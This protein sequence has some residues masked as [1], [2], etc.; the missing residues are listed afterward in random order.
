MHN[1][2][3][4]NLSIN[5]LH[6]LNK[7]IIINNFTS[8]NSVITIYHSF[9]IGITFNYN[10]INDNLFISRYFKLSCN[11]KDISYS[12][13]FK[14]WNKLQFKIKICTVKINPSSSI[15]S[16]FIYLYFSVLCWLC[17]KSSNQY[18]TNDCN[19]VNLF[20]FF[21]C[22]KFQLDFNL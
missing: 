12:F 8:N 21:N 20:N 16:E 10:W 1:L 11:Q 17:T 22:L 5:T 7:L 6:P 2:K 13:Y 14:F 15:I 9:C 18:K 19:N 3:E 4:L